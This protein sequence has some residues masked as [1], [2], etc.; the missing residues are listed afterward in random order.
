MKAA[1]LR[2]KS[3]AELKTV[4]GELRRKQFKLRLVKGSG[5]LEK[6]HEI[7]DV[8]RQIARLETVLTQK[9]GKRDE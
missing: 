7:K 3:A 2:D 4:L 1:E 5:E 9:E 8:R 6:T